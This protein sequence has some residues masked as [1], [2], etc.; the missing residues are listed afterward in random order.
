MFLARIVFFRLHE[1]PRYLVHAGRPQEAIESLQLISRFN[2]SDLSLELDDVRDHHNRP[3][4]EA[5]IEARS[6]LPRDSPVERPRASSTTILNA[7]GSENDPH[8][9]PL[10]TQYSST[11]ASPNALDSH[12]F[13]IPAREHPPAI[14]P[15]ANKEV[16]PTSPR[17]PSPSPASTRSPRTRPRHTRQSSHISICSRRTSS[18]GCY[19][20]PR[21]FRRPLWA[22]SDRV[23]MVLSP[24]WLRTTVLVWGTWFFMSLGS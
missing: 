24:E 6:A 1:S 10:I 20:L 5:P 22:W 17:L 14:L 8:H 16:K 12:F 21:K 23:A 2:G 19:L 9:A 4:V 11:D 18:H 7:S 3:D 13:S 15:P